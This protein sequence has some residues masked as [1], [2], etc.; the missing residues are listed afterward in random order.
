LGKEL[1]LEEGYEAAKIGVINCLAAVK[2]VIW[3]FR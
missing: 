2:S 3:F 1:T